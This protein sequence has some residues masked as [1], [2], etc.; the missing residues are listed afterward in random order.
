MLNYACVDAVDVC[1]SGRSAA[2]LFQE[3]GV[4]IKG[5]R[6]LSWSR[7]LKKL[8]CVEEKTD[9][10]LAQETE[11]DSIEFCEVDNFVFSLL[12]KY[13]LRHT[14]LVCLVNDYKNGCF[15]NGTAEELI[16]AI[17]NAEFE[18]LQSMQQNE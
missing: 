8:L 13:Q 5:Q 17:C 2:S 3:Y 6:Q 18:R 12:C 1:G 16:T 9:E 11:H 10:E 14:Y 4:A 15:G 7:G